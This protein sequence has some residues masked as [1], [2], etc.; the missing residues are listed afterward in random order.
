MDYVNVLKQTYLAL[1]CV[2]VQEVVTKNRMTFK[3]VSFIIHSIMK[4]IFLRMSFYCQL[5]NNNLDRTKLYNGF[6]FLRTWVPCGFPYKPYIGICKAV[7]C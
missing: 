5:C 4:L 2:L 6:T 7:F 3:L 1:H